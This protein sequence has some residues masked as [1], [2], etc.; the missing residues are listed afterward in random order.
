MAV[1]EELEELARTP[2]QVTEVLVIY[3]VF[4]ALQLIMLEAAVDGLT[5]VLLVLLVELEAEVR[6]AMALVA[7][8]AWE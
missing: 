5:L 8:E 7:R 2:A 4:Q 1:R 6:E 3:A